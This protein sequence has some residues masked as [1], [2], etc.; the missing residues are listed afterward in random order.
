MQGPRSHADR[1]LNEIPSFRHTTNRPHG[2]MVV[3]TL[4]WF[5]FSSFL[6]S[7]VRAQDV[8]EVLQKLDAGEFSIREAATR[9]LIEMGPQAIQPISQAIRNGSNEIRTRGIFVLK[10]IAKTEE[11]GA[12]EPARLAIESLRDKSTPFLERRAAA[13][14]AELNTLRE[15]KTLI[16][17]QER[18]GVKDNRPVVAGMFVNQAGVYALSLNTTWKGKFEDL[19][20]L[21]Y[22]TGMVT[23]ELTGEWVNDEII[24]VVSAIKHLRQLSIRKAKITNQTPFLLAKHE[25]LEGF[26]LRYCAV[27]DDCLPA[28][29]RF[30][31]LAKLMLV[32]TKISPEVAIELE[33]LFGASVV[34]YRRGGFLGVS[35]ISDNSGCRVSRVVPE[36]S[37]DKVG[38]AVGDVIQKINDTQVQTS[39]QLI[40][41]ISAYEIGTEVSVTWLH[42]GETKVEKAALGEYQDLD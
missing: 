2:Q 26:E 12:P 11:I 39:E 22:L 8:Q 7:F 16:F 34:D 19:N 28:L 18:G 30:Q 4:A 1:Q 41:A 37:A 23:L 27:N 5:I 20:R 42:R 9:Q 29:K 36:S 25:Q 15:A 17:F 40:E 38:I 32:G 6:G 3:T 10:E 33:D 35:C 21:Q 31:F 14:I 24:E 13:V